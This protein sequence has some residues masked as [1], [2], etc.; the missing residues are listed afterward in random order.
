[1]LIAHCNILST[2]YAKFLGLL[3]LPLLFLS[4]STCTVHVYTTRTQDHFRQDRH[5]SRLF[6]S[7]RTSNVL[8]NTSESHILPTCQRG[9]KREREFLTCLQL[10]FLLPPP[11]TLRHASWRAP[12]AHEP[13]LPWARAAAA[14]QRLR[15]SSSSRA[16]DEEGEEEASSHSR[17]AFGRPLP[18]SARPLL[19]WRG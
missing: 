2:F 12:F 10:L 7:R 8:L 9:R 13:P 15:S 4:L 3:S 1:M 14:Q 16:R 17:Q 19:A 6:P 5:K 11:R 18:L